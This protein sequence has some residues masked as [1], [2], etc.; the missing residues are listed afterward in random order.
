MTFR[1][2]NGRLVFLFVTLS[3]IISSA[4]AFAPPSTASVASPSTR[5]QPILALS[6]QRGNNYYN[7]DAFGF[8]FLGGSAIS[9]DAVF[10]TVF[11]I[12]SAVAALL[13]NLQVL[14]STKRV[15]AAVAGCTLLATPIAAAVDP[16]TLFGV[17]AVPVPVENARI[18]Q[19]VFCSVSIAYGLFSPDEHNT[20]ES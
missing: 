8:I 6:S 18:I 10:A 14:P 19:F 7:D 15:P 20:T 3:S 9:Q 17:G 12:L 4:L 5:I 13:T 2:N 11:L 1:G 16:S